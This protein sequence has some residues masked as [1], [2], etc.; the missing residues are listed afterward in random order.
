MSDMAEEELKRSAP[1]KAFARRVISRIRQ[2][3]VCLES[4]RTA[5]K[6]LS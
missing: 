1:R 4:P 5:L 2:V 3:R 6:R